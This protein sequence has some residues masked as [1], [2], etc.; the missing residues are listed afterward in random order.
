MSIRQRATGPRVQDVPKQV[1]LAGDHSKPSKVTA[2]P[3]SALKLKPLTQ[4]HTISLI[5]IAF[6]VT[7]AAALLISFYW[8][9]VLTEIPRQLISLAPYSNAKNPAFGVR[10]L[11]ERGKGLIAVRNIRVGI[12][13]YL[14]NRIA[15]S[16]QPHREQRGEL[17]IREKPLILVP[18]ES[19]RLL[20]STKAGMV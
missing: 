14:D 12:P 5:H 7:C 16:L 18:H 9:G 3:C 10:D 19:K 2:I 15:D 4:T 13:V 1:S 20:A 17:L 8:T 6:T 11:P